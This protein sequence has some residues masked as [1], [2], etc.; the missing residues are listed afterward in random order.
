[1]LVL[2]N[3]ASAAG[4]WFYQTT[5]S[6]RVEGDDNRQLSADD[7]QGTVGVD[8][9]STFDISRRTET[10]S[11]NVQARL[12]S[13]R[14]DGEQE[15]SALDTD[16]QE[17]RLNGQWLIPRGQLSLNGSFVRRSSVLTELED[18]GVLTDVE[19]RVTKSIAPQFNYVYSKIHKF[20]GC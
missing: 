1:M 6:G 5:I 15:D 11:V 7:E 14:Y 16:D 8:L 17:L 13:A 12:R 2:P 20:F 9:S 19:R 10:S 18:S 4:N 3:F